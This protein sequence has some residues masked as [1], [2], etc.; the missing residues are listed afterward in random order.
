MGLAVS[1]PSFRIPSMEYRKLPKGNEEIG[2]IGLGTAYLYERSPEEIEKVFRRAFELGFNH[3]DLA[4]GGYSVYKPLGKAMEGMRDKVHLQMHLGAIYGGEEGEYGWGRDLRAIKAMFQK[5]L[6]DLRTDY[7]D[8]L[9]LHCVDDMDDLALLFSSGVYGY[10]AE[11]KKEGKARHLGFSSH[12]PAVASA[13]LDK[14]DFDLF[15]FSVNPAYDLEE[16]GEFAIGSRSER[17]ALFRKARDLG[18]AI[19]VMKPFLGGK[20]L[21]GKAS[22]FKKA[23]DVHKCIA[24]ALDTPGVVTVMAGVSG[25]DDLEELSRHFSLSK[26]ELDYSCFLELK[27]EKAMG[28]CVYCGHCLPCP[29]NIDI[30]LVNKYYDLAR[31]GDPLAAGHYGKLYHKASEC[32]RCGHCDARCPFKVAQSRRMAEIAEYFGE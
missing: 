12:T 13:L 18:V 8:F 3:V 24:Y 1:A 20:L 4:A 9:F 30:G 16:G 11:L 7:A 10:A 25:M 28:E 29:A 2:V 14:G 15:M 27:S 21:D 19:S 32:L 5:E 17:A 22:P 31:L 6:E 23:M 26:E